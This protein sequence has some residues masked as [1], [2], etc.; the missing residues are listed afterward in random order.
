M[1]TVPIAEIKAELKTMYPGYRYDM[2]AIPATYSYSLT[3]FK[4]QDNIS[5]LIF[6]AE[7]P[8][9]SFWEQVKDW[10]RPIIRVYGA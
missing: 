1:N 2:K 3:V 5:T 9:T 10:M 7:T 4:G 6:K 8:M